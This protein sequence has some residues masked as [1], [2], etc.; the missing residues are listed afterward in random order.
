MTAQIEK[1]V[2]QMIKVIT[3]TFF[4]TFGSMMLNYGISLMVLRKTGSALSFGITI[5][6]VPLINLVLSPF[7]GHYADKYDRKKIILY[8]Q[9]LSLVTLL[10]FSIMYKMETMPLVLMVS[11]IISLL[12]VGDAFFSSA[13]NASVASIVRDA[14]IQKLSSFKQTMTA[15]SQVLAPLLGA[16]LFAL[17]NFEF[18]I[19]LVAF[20]ELL[21]LIINQTIDYKLYKKDDNHT[22]A[23]IE[24]NEDAFKSMLKTLKFLMKSKEAK[25]LFEV[26]I[27]MNFFAAVIV[28]GIPYVLL[29]EFNATDFQY[30]LFQVSAVLGMILF[31]IYYGTSKR[32]EGNV[33]RILF[34]C[35]LIFGL[36]LGMLSI[37]F[38]I[39]MDNLWKI[40]IYIIFSFGFGVGAAIINV[41]LNIFFHK[42]IHE[43]LKGRVFALMTA[44]MSSL[45]PLG[46]LFFGILFDVFSPRW[47]FIG[48]GLIVTL[49]MIFYYVRVD[50]NILKRENFEG[51]MIE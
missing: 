36:L 30:S 15:G 5:L 8:S 38:F 50:K 26:A 19:L 44:L 21:A 48:T 49:F 41:P 16:F 12:A 45:V 9:V 17:M 23:K 46:T 22:I 32:E 6:L 20:L 13:S 25:S 43:S 31:S 47:I 14:D 27:M 11:I 3:T 40:I 42:H 24:E 4:G 2:K 28:V 51:F 1:S 18:Y 10:I 34:V 33:F 7:A 39:H 37:P 35:S 29:N